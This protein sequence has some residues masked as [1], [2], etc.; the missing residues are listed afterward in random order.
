MLGLSGM[1]DVP[2]FSIMICLATTN[3]LFIY[4]IRDDVGCLSPLIFFI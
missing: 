1:I 2:K 3:S 4:F